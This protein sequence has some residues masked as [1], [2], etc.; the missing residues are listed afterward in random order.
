MTAAMLPDFELLTNLALEATLALQEEPEEIRP[1]GSDRRPGGLIRLDEDLPCLILPDLHARPGLIEL[2][3]AHEIDEGVTLAEALEAGRVQ[4]LFLGDGLHSENP[5]IWEAATREYLSGF[6]HSPAM[7]EEMRQ[8]LEC[9]GLVMSLKVRHPRLVHFLKGNHENVMDEK[10]RGNRSCMK[11]GLETPMVKEWLARFAGDRFLGIW[12]RFEKSLPLLARGKGF[13][14]SHALPL[15]VW[16]EQRV[17]DGM[18]KDELVMDLTWS[19]PRTGQD[20]ITE[21][22]L[23]ALL[24]GAGSWFVGHTP[25]QVGLFRQQKSGAIFLHNPE[26]KSAAWVEPGRPFDPKESVWELG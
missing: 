7:N 6:V 4:L 8:G 26:K 22:N 9:M 18:G 20:E 14:A 25:V 24:G 1:R 16:D 21:K 12:D 13:L 3:L 15:R 10:L 11:Y 19:R 5:E 17:I 2:A 23:L